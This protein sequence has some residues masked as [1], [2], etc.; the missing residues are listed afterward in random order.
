MA[1]V[2]DS[3][4]MGGWVAWPVYLSRTPSLVMSSE[5]YKQLRAFFFKAAAR[6]CA[7]TRQ[8]PGANT[9]V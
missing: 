1:C 4:V 8:R 6:L 7:V 5:A 3:G 9:P 2:N